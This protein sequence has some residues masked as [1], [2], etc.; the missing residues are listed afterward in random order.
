MKK[1]MIMLAA[2]AMA[3]GAQAASVYWTCTYVAKA[4]ESYV[5]E[6]L[7]FFVNADTLSRDAMLALSG[8]G[9][10]KVSEA[11]NGFYSYTGGE[12]GKY[13][14]SKANAVA[15]GTLGL[16]DASASSAYLVIF[17]TATITDSSNFYVTEVKNFDTYSGTEVQQVKWGDQEELSSAAG[18]WHATA[19]A[20]PEPTSGLLMLVGLAGLALRR[21]RA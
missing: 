2:V 6:G 7:A 12:D 16:A 11:L 20:V 15:N 10:T 18:A 1:L 4:P 8:Q 3:V 13:S 17:D 21:R 9:A 19:A 14:M 5:N